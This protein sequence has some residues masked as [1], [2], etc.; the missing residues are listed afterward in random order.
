MVDLFTSEKYL[1]N[2]VPI[3]LVF[4][5]AP[6]DFVV[7]GRDAQLA[8]GRTDPKFQLLD[9]SLFV[10]KVKLS[11]TLLIAHAKALQ[12]SRAVYPIRRPIIKVVNLAN[13]HSS[14]VI[15]NIIMGT[16]AA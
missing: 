16:I 15:E 8:L 13:G 1:I 7:M 6:N 4:T 3:H 12:I 5:R 9:I 14:F 11:P 2:G 10:R